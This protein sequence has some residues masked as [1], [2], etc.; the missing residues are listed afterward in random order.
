MGRKRSPLLGRGEGPGPRGGAR[1]LNRLKKAEALSTAA[2]SLFLERG[3]ESVS[4]DDITRE[5][6]IAKG[7]FYRY[8]DDKTALVEHLFGHARAEIEAAF[9]RCETALAHGGSREEMFG[10][11]QEIGATVARLLLEEPMVL[12]LYLQE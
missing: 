3:L 4:I 10:A 5:A 8:F 1:A 2:L 6:G 12:R 11:Y 9:A 7:S